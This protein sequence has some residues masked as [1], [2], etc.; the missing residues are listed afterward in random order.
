[1]NYHSRRLPHSQSYWSIP[2]LP[3][4]LRCVARRQCGAL[5]N[6][7][8]TPM[9]WDLETR[10]PG[11]SPR[12]LYMQLATGTAVPHPLSP[13]L[14][15]LHPS[16]YH[17]YL[18]PMYLHLEWSKAPPYALHESTR[19][20]FNPQGAISPFAPRMGILVYATTQ[21]MGATLCLS[22]KLHESRQSALPSALFTTPNTTA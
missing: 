16:A 5:S 12:L 6:T 11:H 14:D 17:T 1:M 7:L 8:I 15:I 19:Y 22:Y 18:S 4:I 20:R 2:I 3:C 10:L 9:V 21:A 13:P